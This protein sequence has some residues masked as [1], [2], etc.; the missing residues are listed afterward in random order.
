MFCSSFRANDEYQHIMKVAAVHSSNVCNVCCL[1]CLANTAQWVSGQFKFS[2][3]V[4]MNQLILESELTHILATN[5]RA[6]P[7]DAASVCVYTCGPE[8]L[9]TPQPTQFTLWTIMSTPISGEFDLLQQNPQQLHQMEKGTR[10]VKAEGKGQQDILKTG[11]V[12][13]LDM[14]PLQ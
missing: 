10:R 6:P 4:Y 7:G 3:D 2:R 1:H 9:E 5:L 13:A 14:S 12:T 11:A 8:F